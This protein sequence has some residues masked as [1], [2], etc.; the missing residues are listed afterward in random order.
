M[1]IDPATGYVT[2][3]FDKRYGVELVRSGAAFAKP[4]AIADPS[5]TWSHGVLRFD[6]MAGAFTAKRVKLVES[7][8]VRAVLRV[9]SAYEKSTLVQDFVLYAELPAVEV[10]VTV[11]WR[12]HFALLKLMFPVSLDEREL[13]YE[14]PSASST[15]RRTGRRSRSRAGSISRGAS[16]ARRGDTG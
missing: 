6:Q 10:R 7:G 14:I 4:V 1:R 15:G 3:L 11:D 8:P 9:E 2:S 13:T 12:E 16:P 5:D